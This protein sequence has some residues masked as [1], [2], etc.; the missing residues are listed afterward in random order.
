MDGAVLLA[1]ILKMA[2]TTVTT[3]ASC[4]DSRWTVLPVVCGHV[5]W[6]LMVVAGRIPELS[7]PL[8]YE[9]F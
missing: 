7:A 6:V 2:G 1:A 3:L 4:I 9:H 8:G 5:N